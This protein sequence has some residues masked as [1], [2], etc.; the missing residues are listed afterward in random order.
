ML[1]PRERKLII[2]I[3]F[4]NIFAGF[5]LDVKCELEVQLI[6]LT[7][8]SAAGEVREYKRQETNKQMQYIS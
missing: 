2:D 8:V 4:N 6:S 7:I 1:G 5:A 3:N